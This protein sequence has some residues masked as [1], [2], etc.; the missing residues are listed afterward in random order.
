MRLFRASR[1]LPFAVALLVGCTTT[2]PNGQRPLDSGQ[3]RSAKSRMYQDLA[4][5]CLQAEDHERALSLLQQ[6]V[7]FDTG[8]VSSLELLTRLAT[9]SGNHGVA[10]TAAQLLLRAQPGSA[11]ALCTLGAVAEAQDDPA[12]AETAYRRALAAA[13]DDARPAIDLHRL[14]LASGRE[15]EAA[16]LR[17]ELGERYPRRIEPLLDHAAWLADTQRWHE[18]AAAFDQVLARQPGEPAA[19]AGVALGALMSRQPATALALRD[20]LPPRARADNPTLQM[21][22]AIAHLQTGDLEAALRELDCADGAT[23]ERVSARVLRG[24][25]LFR[26]QRHDAAQ[27]EFERAIELAPDTARAHAGLGRILLLQRR[28]HAATR[29]LQRAVALEPANAA[30][31]ALLVAALAGGGDLDAARREFVEI[32]RAHV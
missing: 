3:W 9:A 11:T 2:P 24:E 28:T 18:A 8:D 23:A 29:A 4:R 12:A 32:G 19:A 21:S 7:Q 6:A 14:L 13:P 27:A 1:V 10:T 16:A 26:L 25:I 5:Q 30:T 31:K 17:A 15:H 22:L 20:R